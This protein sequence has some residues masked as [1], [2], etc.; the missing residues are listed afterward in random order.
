MSHNFEFRKDITRTELVFYIK[1]GTRT[2]VFK[3]RLARRKFGQRRRKW[4][5]AG[6]NCIMRNFSGLYSSPNIVRAIK[7]RRM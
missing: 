5:K 3:N 7:S 2:E 1:E 4:Q 6:E